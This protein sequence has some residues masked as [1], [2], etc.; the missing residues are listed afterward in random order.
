[1][2]KP[3]N[4]YLNEQKKLISE[5]QKKLAEL[6]H[7]TKIAKDLDKK[8]KE[9]EH[10]IEVF[11]SKLPHTSEVHTVLENVT[12]IAQKH[13]LEAELVKA[14]KQVENNG[15]I[16]QPLEM[17]LAGNFKS[18]YGFLLELERLDRITKIRELKLKKI[19]KREGYTGVSF[20]LSIF[21]RG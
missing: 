16:E 19:N 14:L 1:M 2:I 6:E 21:F 3:A 17:H 15:Y 10:A 9:I 4:E 18:F 13:G 8:L 12:R 20:A 11:E 5:K 7:A